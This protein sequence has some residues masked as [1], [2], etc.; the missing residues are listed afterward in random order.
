MAGLVYNDE[1]GNNKSLP[2]LQLRRL[3]LVSGGLFTS[4]LEADDA[5][6]H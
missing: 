5:K 1:R 6:P 3:G 4:D 2:T